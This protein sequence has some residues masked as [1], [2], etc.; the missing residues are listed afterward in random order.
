METLS[1]FSPDMEIYSIDEAFLDLSGFKRI[2]PEHYGREIRHKV[3]RW[4]GIPVSVGIA[5]TKTLA[6]IAGDLAKKSLK[7]GGVLNLD[8][9]PYRDRALGV[10]DIGDVWGIG[11][12]LSKFLKAQGINTALDFAETDDVWVKKYMGI[13]GV[14]TAR[15]LRGI[16]SIS[17]ASSIPAKKADMCIP[18]VR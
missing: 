18:F 3:L 5:E 2:D 1:R 10:T 9:S 12:R 4:T 7:T 13:T 17:M 6:K 14:R 11:R 15:E 16:P 8:G